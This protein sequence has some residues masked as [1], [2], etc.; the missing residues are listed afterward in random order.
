MKTT[1]DLPDEMVRRAK[2]TAVERGT[3]LR[4]LVGEALAREL[5]IPV[6]DVYRRRRAAF[7]IFSSRAP[8]TMSLTNADL[9]RLEDGEDVRRHGR[10]R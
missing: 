5:E 6:P 10:A 1:L 3:T 9:A 8:G 7:P 2:I 4:N